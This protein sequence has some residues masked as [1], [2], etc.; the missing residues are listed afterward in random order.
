MNLLP[1]I[2]N[3][4]WMYRFIMNLRLFQT[5]TSGLI[6]TFLKLAQNAYKVN[7]QPDSQ[8]FNIYVY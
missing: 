7:D 4:L 3:D 6:G 8:L 5:E 1:L 2:T